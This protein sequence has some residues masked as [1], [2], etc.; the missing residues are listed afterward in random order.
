ME[1]DPIN[2]AIED[3]RGNFVDMMRHLLWISS[4]LDTNPETASAEDGKEKVAEAVG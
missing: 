2:D 3:E 1:F 4:A